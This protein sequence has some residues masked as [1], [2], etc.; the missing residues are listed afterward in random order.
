MNT[1]P[2]P[3]ASIDMPFHFLD[4]LLAKAV[5]QGQTE[6]VDALLELRA[7][8]KTLSENPSAT[9]E[10]YLSLREPLGGLSRRDQKLLANLVSHHMRIE[11]TTPSVKRLMPVEFQWDNIEQLCDSYR[12]VEFEYNE[13]EWSDIVVDVAS[14]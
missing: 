2:V 1:F 8:W 6:A 3:P 5:Q 13:C 10:K 9:L 11:V 4:Q 7:G 12:R 14:N